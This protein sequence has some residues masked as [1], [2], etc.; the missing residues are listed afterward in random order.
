MSATVPVRVA[1]VSTAPL[2]ADRWADAE[3]V[4]RT[5]GD[6]ARCWCQW[7][8]MRN[9]DWQQ[10]RVAGNRDALR[11]QTEDGPPPG[12]LGYLDGVPAGW[13]AV[14]PRADLPRLVA[15]TKTRDAGLPDLLDRGIW[16]VT[17]FVVVPAA[18]R[19]GLA[20]VLLD[21]ALE[22]A[23]THGAQAVEAYPVD[24][25]VTRP[26][27]SV[28]FHGALSTFLAAGFRETGRTAP[29]RPVVSRLLGPGVELETGRAAGR[30]SEETDR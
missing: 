18:R 22:L 29:A 10:A 7:F 15:S 9:A 27:T 16:A 8:R 26:S 24:T 28:L 5:K 6:P 1:G 13:C 21:A 4:F 25:A 17:C 14:A 19:Q 2:T 12:V 23:W 30:T 20:G 11:R 3:Q